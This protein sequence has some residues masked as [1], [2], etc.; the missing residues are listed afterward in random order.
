MD[1]AY[2]AGRSHAAEGE[3]IAHDTGQDHLLAYFVGVQAW[4]AAVRGEDA[5]ELV[6]RALLLGHAQRVRPAVAIAVWAAALSELGAG[7]W[8]EAA[9]RL[10]AVVPAGA[11]DHHPAIALQAS[12]DLAEAAVRAERPELAREIADADLGAVAPWACALTARARGLAAAD[13]DAAV[14]EFEAALAHHAAGDRRFEEARTRLAYGE[15][16]RRLKQRRAARTQLRAAIDVFE[17]LGAAPWE[18]RARNEL[19]ATG[20]TAR[21]RDPSTLDQLT[22][23]ELQ[24]VRLVAEGATNK[25]I[26][27]Q[28][29]ISPRTVAY[30]LRNVFVKL[31][32][33]SRAELI[34]FDELR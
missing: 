32:I 6:A 24:I 27:A 21:K 4:I 28:L 25:A 15:R 9:T 23:Q 8:A 5:A 31:G 12:A 22:P 14:A 2:P 17:R 1:G 7:Q 10:E 20:E 11:P 33:S 30:H 29:F 19:R 26:G 16:L 18:Q 34:R 3:R 13:D